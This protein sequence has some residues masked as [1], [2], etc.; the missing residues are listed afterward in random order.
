MSRMVTRTCRRSAAQL[1]GESVGESVGESPA[2]LVGESQSMMF[3]AQVT[4]V[5]RQSA[6]RV[7]VARLLS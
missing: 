4:V 7:A 3:P 5:L 6:T 2:Q 1:G